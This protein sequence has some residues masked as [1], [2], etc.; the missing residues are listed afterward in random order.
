VLA[1]AVCGFALGCRGSVPAAF[2]SGLLFGGCL[3]L[4]YGLTLAGVFPAAVLLLTRRVWPVLPAV[5]GVAVVVAAFTGAGFWWWS[6][7]RLTRLLYAQPLQFGS[8]DRSYGYW[9]WAAP[10]A[11]AVTLGPA[12]LAGVRRALTGLGS[13]VSRSPGRGDVPDG[14][15]GARVLGVLA[16]AALLAVAAADLSGLSRGET[17]RIWLPFAMWLLPAAGLLPARHARWWLAVQVL[18]A[19]AVN[20]LLDPPW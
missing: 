17:E 11:F 13:A 20:H 4:S 15:A 18:L 6:G 2:G 5:A 9:V 19:L 14:A 8:A 7:Y 1:W 12:V 16:G 10:A 3:Y